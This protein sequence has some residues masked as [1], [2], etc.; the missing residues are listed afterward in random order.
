MIVSF[1]KVWKEA[2]DFLDQGIS[3][4]PVRDKPQTFGGREYPVKSAFPWKEYQTKI[5]K[6]NELLYLFEKYDTL[7][8]GIVGG[9]V[10]GNLEIIDIDVKNWPGIDTR[11][12][13]DIKSLFP[14]LWAQLRI[15]RSPS[16]GYHIF[17]RISDHAAD[18]NKKLAF[19]EGQK[20]AAIETRGEGG[21]VVG[22]SAMG[23]SVIND[24]PIP[25]ISWVERC[26][27]IAIC[28][29][30]NQKVKVQ[31]VVVSKSQSDYYDEDPWSHYNASPAAE[32]ILTD[33]GWSLAGSSNNFIWYTRPGKQSGVSASFNREKRI[34]YIF[35]SSTELEPSRGYQP[36]T[37][38]SI[39]QFNNDKKA[40]YRWLVD[41]GYGRV[42]PQIEKRKL[43]TISRNPS[44][45]IPANF[46][47]DAKIA[48]TELRQ[49]Y[50]ELHPFGVFWKSTDKGYTISRE[51]I[52][53][54]ASQLGFRYYKGN[55]V[56][57]DNMLIHRIEERDFQD[58]LKAYIK[59]PDLD[60]Y[61]DICNAYEA[62]MQRSGKFMMSR[63]PMLDD[64][65]ILTDTKQVSYKFYRNG[66]LTIDDKTIIF[67]EYDSLVDVLIWADR[68]QPRNYNK[69]KGGK[70][71]EFLKLATDPA[72][73]E[74]VK[75]CIGYLAHEYKDE[76]TGYIIVLT[77]Q[78][79]D[80]KQ[81]GGSG[82]NVFCNLLSNVTTYTSKPGSQAKFDEKFFQSWNGQRIFCI[83]D[84]P[85]NFDFAFLK[86][87]STG[88]FIWKKLFKDEVEIKNSEAPKFVVQ[89]NFSYEISDGGLR[90]R[91]IPIEFTNFFTQ[92]GGL[93]IYFKCHFPAGWTTEDWA[94]FDNYIA[95]AIQLWL[96]HERKLAAPELTHTGWVKQ[97][98]QTYGTTIA[99]I[100]KEYWQSW[101]DMGD[102]SNERFK[103]DLQAFYSDANIQKHY[104][105][106]TQKINA[107][108]K[109]WGAKQGIFVE[110][111]QIKRIDMMPTK[112]RSFMSMELPF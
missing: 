46:S 104:Q 33:N 70:Y 40:A 9:A 100:I 43:Q 27:L 86:E 62:F 21:Y 73:S 111:D 19:K 23:Y 85:K 10:S 28:E 48:A 17:Y 26:S 109:E 58:A 103:N 57:I 25:T 24:K 64:S 56:R 30:Y 94:G 22:S 38:L 66:F 8:F 13:Q 72:Q 65:K 61:E 35:T 63:L 44:A 49:T 76:T 16:G 52:I 36:A 3:I 37:L 96:I 31:P 89:T 93:D 11:L 105:P 60:M 80:P 14:H 15:H 110:V 101:V 39:L 98:E 7:G 112:C 51:V 50:T 34:F 53:N 12:F 32:N 82:K 55:V 75:R 59:E 79:Q 68:C 4:I 74:H 67:S 29:G 78:C 41:N 95:E 92:K 5:I 45:P 2:Q 88:S 87:P 84:V 108:L 99:Q 90:R 71:E 54:V 106:S 18:G 83:S 69:G 81:G 42:K 91:I 1:E 77:E 47:E 107:A 102:V 6:K 97:F 20:E